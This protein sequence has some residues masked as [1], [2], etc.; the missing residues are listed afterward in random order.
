M[1][2]FGLVIVF[3]LS[4]SIVLIRE[5]F[6]MK[7]LF[8]TEAQKMFSSVDNV[9]ITEEDLCQLPEQVQKYLKKVGVIGK[10][11][12]RTFH[13][14]MTGEIQFKQD[15]NYYA[16]NA[17][18]YTSVESGVR[19]FYMTMTYN[20]LPINGFHHYSS[21]DAVMQIKILDLIKIVA[22]SGCQ[23]QRAET[24]T[25]F[26]DLCIMAPAALLEETIR[27]E[28]IDKR[29]VKGILIKHGHEVAA[30]LHF[31]EDCMLVNFESEDRIDVHAD[32][33]QNSTLWST[34]MT[35]FDT[36]GEY[37]LPSRGAAIWHYP[38][39]DFTYIRLN[40]KN[41]MVNRCSMHP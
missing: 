16:L 15:G 11:R 29:R 1:I 9:L 12:V 26:N 22:Y 41:V 6:G 32:S 39:H 31:N 38:S 2:T 8:K 33:I 40:I 7:R 36:I 20:G 28:V 21:S 13:V 3:T 14:K 35:S 25:Y 4:L 10:P 23:L 34:P 27:W 17:E 24:V 5:H 30:V 18:Q 19:L 37:Y